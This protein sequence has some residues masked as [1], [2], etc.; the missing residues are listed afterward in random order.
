MRASLN[1]TA[2]AEGVE[3]PDV[4]GAYPTPYPAGVE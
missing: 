2:I 4:A 3:L 1:G